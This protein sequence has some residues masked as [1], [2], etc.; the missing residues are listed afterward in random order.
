M[1]WPGRQLLITGGSS[2]IGAATAIAAAERGADVALLARSAEKLE[3]VA[4][5]IRRIGG[6]VS[7]HVADVSNPTQVAEIAA[8]LPPPDVVIHSA[9]AG[10]WRPLLDTDPAEAAAM[11]AAPYLAAF[12]VTRAF[13][14]AMIA[15]RSGAMV[16]VNSAASRLVWPGAAAY[17]AGR[18]ALRGLFEAVRM[19][20]TGT[21]VRTAM[22]TFAKVA[23]EYWSNNPDSESRVPRVQSLV[24]V[25]SSADAARAL[26]DG[27]AAGRESIVA[28]WQLRLFFLANHIAPSIVRS[29]MCGP[30]RPGSEPTL[31]TS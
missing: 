9:G 28:P 30:R 12:I 18:W 16:F 23:S 20:T 8:R 17:I 29:R 1:Q 25:L 31:P 26:L 7:L 27:L 21:G 11:M 6:R 14:P 15:R 3:S 4:H 5:R 19:E 10:A 13:L 2:G 24:P 22:A